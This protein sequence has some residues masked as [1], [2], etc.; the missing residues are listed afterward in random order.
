[1]ARVGFHRATTEDGGKLPDH[2]RP[3]NPDADASVMAYLKWLEL[4]EGKTGRADTHFR[5][6]GHRKGGKQLLNTSA[7]LVGTVVR[8]ELNRARSFVQSEEPTIP[9]SSLEPGGSKFFRTRELYA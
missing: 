1:V 7:G 4:P 6:V 8:N 3:D 5:V 9:R 2:L